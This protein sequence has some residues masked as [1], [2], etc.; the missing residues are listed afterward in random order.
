MKISNYFYIALSVMPIISIWIM[1]TIV[2]LLLAVLWVDGN[3]RIL[4]LVIY[5]LMSSAGGFFSGIKI[6]YKDLRDK[7]DISDTL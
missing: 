4:W 5:I 2:T 3:M 7:L 1:G 6:T